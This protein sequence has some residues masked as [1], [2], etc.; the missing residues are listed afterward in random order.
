MYTG[1]FISYLF[2]VVFLCVGIAN[3]GWIIATDR[4]E[5]DIGEYDNPIFVKKRNVDIYFGKGQAPENNNQVQRKKFK[6]TD[7]TTGQF[8]EIS[9]ARSQV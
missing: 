1:R 9:H 2:I 8:F 4:E 5:E 7:L 3:A 6:L